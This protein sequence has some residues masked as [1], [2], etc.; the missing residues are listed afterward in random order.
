MWCMMRECRMPS[1]TFQMDGV[2][3]SGLKFLGSL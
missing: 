3:D 2:S 1:S